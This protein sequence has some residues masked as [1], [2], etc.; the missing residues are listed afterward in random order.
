[1]QWF[2]AVKNNASVVYY[3]EI[4]HRTVWTFGHKK[5][6]PRGRVRDDGDQLFAALPSPPLPFPKQWLSDGNV[7]GGVGHR[8]PAPK[9]QSTTSVYLFGVI[10]PALGKVAG[11]ILPFCNTAAMA[12]HMEE[13]S[14][15]AAPGAHAL[16]LV[17]QARW[18]LSAELKDMN[19]VC[20]MILIRLTR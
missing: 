4:N 8:P 12:L 20:G 13:V 1:M 10:C 2:E 11:L 7:M 14:L 16:L 6:R 9:D 17:D 15:A 19:V 5:P 18:H 3:Y